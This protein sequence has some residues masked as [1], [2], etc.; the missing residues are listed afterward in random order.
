[1]HDWKDTRLWKALGTSASPE[2]EDIQAFLRIWMK[3]IQQV[4]AS[5]GTGPLDFTLHDADHSYR[6]AEWMVDIVPGDVIDHLS[7][8]ELAL[9]LLSAYLHDIGMTPEQE[10]VQRHWRHL[11][12][13]PSERDGLT[14]KEA[15]DFQRWLDDERDGLVPP[16]AEEGRPGDDDLHLAAELITYYARHKHNDWSEEWIRRNASGDLGS[17]KSWVD[18]LVRI[19]RS[20]HYGYDELVKPSFDPLPAGRKG[21]VVNLR[22]L[23]CVLRIADILDIDPERTPAVLF[24]HRAIVPKSVIFWRKDH[25][26]SIYSDGKAL[27]VHASPQSAVIEK[28]VRDTAEWIRQELETC[29]R[30]ARE[31]PFDHASFRG[32]K[33]LPHRWDFPELLL[34]QVRPA[35]DEYVYID[36]AFRPNTSKLLELL[37]GT[38]LYKEPLAAVRELLQNAFDAVKEQIALDRLALNDPMDPERVEAITALQSVELRF[39][40][41]GGRFWLVCADTGVGMTRQIIE[42]FLLVSGNSRRHDVLDLE[43]R[44]EAVG[45]RLGRTGQFGIGVLSYFM[46]ADRVEI[47]TRRTLARGDAE[48]HGWLFETEGVGSFGGLKKECEPKRGTTVRLRLRREVITDKQEFTSKLGA[49]LGNLLLHVPCSFRYSIV[50]GLDPALFIGAGWQPIEREFAVSQALW[51]LLNFRL[52][53]T[54]DPLFSSSPVIGQADYLKEREGLA[55]LYHSRLHWAVEEGDLPSGLGSYRI[56]VPYFDLP[57]G[58]CGVFLALAPCDP[59]YLRVPHMATEPGCVVPSSSLRFS[60]MGMAVDRTSGFEW[61][62]KGAYLLMVDW[63]DR[64]SGEISVARNTFRLSSLAAGASRWLEN[65]LLKRRATTLSDHSIY[66]T[67]NARLSYAVSDIAESWWMVDDEHGSAWRRVLPPFTLASALRGRVRRGKIKWQGKPLMVVHGMSLYNSK[68][69]KEI[70]F[71]FGLV[72]VES[73]SPDRIFCVLGSELVLV[74][75]FLGPRRPDDELKLTEFPPAWEILAGVSFGNFDVVNSRNPVGQKIFQVLQG[76][77]REGYE[78]SGLTEYREKPER[79][80]DSLLRRIFESD[81]DLAPEFLQDLWKDIFSMTPGPEYIGIWKQKEQDAG[82]LLLVSPKGV[83]RIASFDSRI[84]HYLPDPGPEWKLTVSYGGNE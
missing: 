70:D 64:R 3:Q 76:P 5:G 50:G 43:R 45:F 61:A 54:P 49:H 28:A 36:G 58:R 12:F 27:V 7:A 48:L 33:P 17:Y 82:M 52:L 19:C 47:R 41:Q 72:G 75:V 77:D 44:C 66:A 32:L 31:K 26:L 63:R 56:A 40:E 14:E 25:H 78:H 16:L 15:A 59:P 29:A 23:A 57:G 21:E 34:L 84:H 80:A 18:D 9:L 67:L 42:K 55:A 35:N 46:L 10:K 69:G 68:E 39:E 73:C 53:R 79:A 74:P 13:G 8:Y 1:M 81:E 62:F 11:V 4:L 6:V 51:N 2:K 38:Q 83:E 65:R 20:H 60:F 22:Y 24:H 71:D 30:L 37:S